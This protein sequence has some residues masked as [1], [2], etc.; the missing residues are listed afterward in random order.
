MM[1]DVMYHLP[2]LDPKGKHVVTEEIV[3]GVR[4]MFDWKTHMPEKKSA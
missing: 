3:L 2:D 1:L 4:N